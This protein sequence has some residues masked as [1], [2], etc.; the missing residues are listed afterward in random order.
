MT[1]VKGQSGNPGGRAKG[2]KEVQDLARQYTKKAI[3]TLVKHLDNKSGP[4]AI[5]AANS[6][7][8]R[9]WGKAPQSVKIGG[10]PEGVPVE[11][12]GAVEKLEH[13]VISAAAGI[14]EEDGP[15]SVN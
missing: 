8:D 14:A 15:Q 3:E 4:A 5:L 13:L 1:F 11:I 10:D 7:I 2:V 6:L 12:V 9:G